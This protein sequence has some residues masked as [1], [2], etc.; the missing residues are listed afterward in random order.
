MQLL[1]KKANINVVLNIV[2]GIE[3]VLRLGLIVIDK[4][5]L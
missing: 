2:S 5:L 1:K 4:Y 3:G